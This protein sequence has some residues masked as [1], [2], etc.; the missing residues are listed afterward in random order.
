[1]VYFKHFSHI[2]QPWATA[3]VQKHAKKRLDFKVV[4]ENSARKSYL[5]FANFHVIWQIITYK[6]MYHVSILSLITLSY[7]CR[8]PKVQNNRFFRKKWRFW[9]FSKQKPARKSSIYQAQMNCIEADKPHKENKGWAPCINLT[10]CSFQAVNCHC[11]ACLTKIDQFSCLWV[12]I[13]SLWPTPERRKSRFVLSLSR[14]YLS[15]NKSFCHIC[16]KIWRSWKSG[17]RANAT[18]FLIWEEIFVEFFSAN[19]HEI[20]VFRLLTGV[21]GVAESNGDHHLTEIRVLHISAF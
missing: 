2:V 7:E 5:G 6:K 21:F 17:G 12:P 4:F 15:T 10:T 18:Y 20:W 13:I 9:P 19:L 8:P 3:R 14:T 11:L 16:L 1:V